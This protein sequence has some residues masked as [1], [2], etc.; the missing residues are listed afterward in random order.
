[1]Q[2]ADIVPWQAATTVTAAWNGIWM[3][4]N[5]MAVAAL[6]AVG[7]LGLMM[8]TGAEKQA[9]WEDDKL[10]TDGKRLSFYE[11]FA[12]F[13][14]LAFRVKAQVLLLWHIDFMVFWKA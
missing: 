13:W 6:W 5:D 3:S 8:G 12:V 4:F 10:A 7:I 9:W 14:G 2:K 11:L 1:M